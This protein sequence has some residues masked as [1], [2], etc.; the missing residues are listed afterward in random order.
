MA[1][2][3]RLRGTIAENRHRENVEAEVA[4]NRGDLDDILMREDED[5]DAMEGEE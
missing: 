2:I 5:A 3:E 1:L 4:E